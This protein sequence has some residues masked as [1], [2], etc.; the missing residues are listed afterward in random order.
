LFSPPSSISLLLHLTSIPL[1]LSNLDSSS[2]IYLSPLPLRGCPRH[3]TTAE[4]RSE[5]APFLPFP[6]SFIINPLFDSNRVFA[7]RPLFTIPQHFL[8]LSRAHHIKRYGEINTRS[9]SPFYNTFQPVLLT[10]VRM[11]NSIDPD[12]VKAATMVRLPWSLHIIGVFFAYNTFPETAFAAG[13]PF[14]HL[15]QAIWRRY[16]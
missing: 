1:S 9:S 7:L 4:R 16:N 2:G 13:A 12:A 14:Y 5:A 11:S 10:F 6:W 8:V 3:R 15:L